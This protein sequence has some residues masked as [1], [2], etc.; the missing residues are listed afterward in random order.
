MNKR[1]VVIMLL[2]ANAAWPQGKDVPGETVP[3]GVAP[4]QLFE[5]LN[6]KLPELA[7]VKAA[8]ERGDEGGAKSA[9]LAHFRSRQDVIKPTSSAAYDTSVADELLKGRFA[10]G[11]MVLYYGPNVT[12]IE[13]YKVPLDIDW[14]TFDHQIGRGTYV[15][16]LS[17]AYRGTGE[18]KYVEHL[19][20]LMLEFI[21]DC[22][23]E[24][25]R[26]MPRIN[27]MD[28]Y[29]VRLI[30]REALASTGH[31][32]MYWTLM[33]AMRRTQQWARFLQYCVSS[34][35]VTP[36]ALA[37]ILTSLIEHERFIVDATSTIKRG[38]HG[39]R[40]AAAILEI[41]AKFPEIAER[42]QWADR[43]LADLLQRYNWK[44]TGPYAFIYPDGATEEISPEVGRGDYSTLLQAM[45]WI[46]M[47]G[48]VMP[49]QL[50]E[51]QEKN[52]EYF[53]YISWPDQ[54]AWRA[55]HKRRGPGL[56]GRADIDYIESGG[57]TGTVPQYASYP[58]RSG[59]PCYAGTY[60]M[61]GSW[62]ADA[63]ALRVRFGPIQYKYSQSGL[64]DVGDIGVWGYGTHL[65]PHIYKHPRTG[66]FR[67]YGDRSFAGDGRSENTI[68][69]DG[70]GQSRFSRARYI[71]EAL[72]NP[73]VTTP[74]FDYV[75]GRYA[76]DPGE[77]EVKHT[78]AILFVKPDY[79]VVM[80]RIDGDGEHDY[81]M[82]YQLHQDLTA[83]ANGVHVVG[84]SA[85]GPGIVVSPSRADLALSIVKGQDE[86]FKE[87]WHLLHEER[88]EAAPALIYEW[89]EQAPSMVETV[90]WPL[91]PGRAPQIRVQR[92]VAAATVTLT[93][94]RADG[95]DVITRDQAGNVTLCRLQNGE[96]VAAGVVGTT[97]LRGH[98]V[99]VT[100]ATAGS[101]YVMRD[102]DRYVTASNCGA[103]V[104]IPETD[105]RVI[106]WDGR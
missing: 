24:D 103:H 104:A 105:V 27:N 32:A 8:W 52:I 67:D 43:G 70:H 46:R 61:R 20:K 2:T 7:A 63:V 49:P 30:G 17:Q 89:H 35:A 40:N 45:G 41:A 39:T 85:T 86:P 47:L 94:T 11:D 48:R 95:T 59:E 14:P 77:V 84:S 44:G 56:T 15:Y 9:L 31:P 3:R 81:R 21:N 12:D 96:L 42:E 1:A 36:D 97:G 18:D 92:S 93:L 57:V 69:V 65:I 80:D 6:V 88:A 22:P 106:E 55:A 5:A 101:T 19:V 91:P 74:V 16:A 38:N 83:V 54:L 87:G 28:G 78:R 99:T 82:K 60:F 53:A 13:W 72:A 73:W 71:E 37:A 58:M 62:T 100:A 90:I 79:F 64:G 102:G 26:A 23:V 51:I 33:A 76:F 4:P 68:S 34:P 66:P 98:G 29:A 75:R 50:L 25:G 10:C